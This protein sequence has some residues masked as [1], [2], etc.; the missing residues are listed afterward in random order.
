[1]TKIHE[2][3][4]TLTNKYCSPEELAESLESIYKSFAYTHIMLEDNARISNRE[5]CNS[6]AVLDILIDGLKGKYSA[7]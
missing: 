5:A 1:M 3:V 6:L 4:D 7:Q 2:A